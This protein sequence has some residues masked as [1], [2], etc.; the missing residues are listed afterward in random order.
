VYCEDQQ[1][2]LKDITHWRN[3]R[4][5]RI[6]YNGFTLRNAELAWTQSSFMQP[7]MMV[8]EPLFLEPRRGQ[9]HR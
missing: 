2:W 9:V 8:Q 5:I 1:L 4:R 3:E 6:G 7:Q